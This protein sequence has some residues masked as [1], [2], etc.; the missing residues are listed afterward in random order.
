M[1][2]FF[3]S[4]EDLGKKNDDHKPSAKNG[5]L[6]PSANWHHARGPPR[7][8]TKRIALVLGI[9]C[10]VYLFIHNIPTDLGPAKTGRPQY[11]ARPPH[12][13]TEQSLAKGASQRENPP[14]D[15]HPSGRTYNGPPKYLALASSLQAISGPRGGMLMNQNI[16]FA[17]SSLK[18]AATLLP[19]ACQMGQELRNYVHFALMS[20][21][22]IA[23]KE[24]WELNGID[25]GCQ[26]IFHGT[27]HS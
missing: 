13:L 10:L 19:M 20:R 12:S 15:L 22:D 5:T 11:G 23:M 4:D 24:L 16:L 8:S 17:A 9:A 21:S 26:I 2:A 18:S 25:E 1:N 14:R 3:L 7:R 6:L 27:D